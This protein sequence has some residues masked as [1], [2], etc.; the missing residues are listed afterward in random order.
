MI[1]FFDT[2]VKIPRSVGFISAILFGILYYIGSLVFGY[3]IAIVWLE[4][5]LI[6]GGFMAGLRYSLGLAA[7]ISAYT[8][9]TIDDFSRA[10]QITVAAFVIATLVGLYSRY[11]HYQM[12]Q[13][14]AAWREAERQRLSAEKSS[15]ATDEIIEAVEKLNG[16]IEK[17]KQAR[18]DLQAVLKNYS[19]PD[20]ARAQLTGV[21]HLLGN[22]ELA[23]TGWRALHKI[24]EDVKDAKLEIVK[25]MKR[26]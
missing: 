18:I 1:R 22:L 8:W 25:R 19:L 6:I 13:N 4:I 11:Q 12:R 17:I 26:D 3:S 24:I 20:G 2:L 7:F 5:F 15:R 21:V 10:A 14:E 16:N 23:T 9:Y